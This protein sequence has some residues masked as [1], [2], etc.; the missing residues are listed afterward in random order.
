RGV[1]RRSLSRARPRLLLRQ[2]WAPGVPARL[3]RL[4]AAQPGSPG[5]DRVPDPRAGAA[6]T[7]ARD[8]AGPARRRGEGPRAAARRA[9]DAPLEQRAPTRSLAAAA[10]RADGSDLA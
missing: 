4:D 9:L 5:G 10:L 3:R 2:R 1:D 6:A 7:G 8:L